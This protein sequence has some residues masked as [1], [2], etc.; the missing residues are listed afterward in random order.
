MKLTCP[1]CRNTC[2][3][4]NDSKLIYVWG[5]KD[6]AGLQHYY[7]YC[8]RCMKVSDLVP[9]G[10][11]A[12]LFLQIRHKPVGVLDP[13]E[14][15]DHCKRHGMEQFGIFAEKIQAAMREDGVIP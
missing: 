5:P 8:R 9:P 1:N 6:E 3:M 12:M 4:P 15:Y 14:V 2:E 7:L 13:K 10:C 11:L